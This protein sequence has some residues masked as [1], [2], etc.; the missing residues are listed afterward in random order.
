MNSAKVIALTE[1][2]KIYNLYTKPTDRLKEALNLNKKKYHSE[3]YALNKITFDVN[4]GETVGI[5]G[6]NG[7]GKSTLLKIISGVLSETSGQKYINGNVSALLELGTGF[8]PEYTGYENI[9]LNGSMRGITKTEMMRVVDSIIEFADI[10]EYIYQP[11]KTYSSGMFARLAF[12]VMINLKPDILIVD[13]ALSVGDVFFQQKCNKYMMN[14]MKGVTKLLVSHDM[15]SIVSMSDRVIVLSKGE[16]V[17]QG[18]PL[19]GIE[20]YTKM[21]HKELFESEESNLI[22]NK[23]HDSWGIGN[24]LDDSWNY[25]DSTKLSGAQKITIN[26]FKVLV[27]GEE[28][29]GYVSK[30]SKVRIN[31]LIEAHKVSSEIIIGYLVNDKFGKPIFGE[32]TFS[33][34]YKLPR[35]HNSK[36]YLVSLEINWPEIQE[37]DYFLTIGIGEGTHEMRHEIQCWAHNVFNFKN[38]VFNQI[39]ALFNNKIE[40][41]EIIEN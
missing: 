41:V 18:A 14:E 4:A 28:Y 19:D 1:I 27:D 36:L 39:H 24:N 35:V 29:K 17:F 31:M 32:N 25:I 8:N 40:K 9:F 2:S 10:G 5:I 26:A 16:I 15:G 22:T 30:E 33:S 21:L 11:V 3:F 38:I 34:G 13:E 6:R 20:F 12:A 37:D 7:S 23:K